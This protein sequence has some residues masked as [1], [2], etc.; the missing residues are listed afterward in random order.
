MNSPALSVMIIVLWVLIMS[1][2]LVWSLALARWNRGLPLIPQAELPRAPWPHSAAIAA[3][4][5]VAFLAYGRLL[6]D[7]SEDSSL[8]SQSDLLATLV[9]SVA[10]WVSV[11]IMLLAGHSH[12]RSAF[13]FLAHR[14]PEQAA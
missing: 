13:G 9:L 11:L 10:I 6:K 12:P 5:W 8:P 4:A 7:L 2:A 3:G 1:S 14:W